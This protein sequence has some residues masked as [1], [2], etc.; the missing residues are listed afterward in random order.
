MLHI[1]GIAQRVWM[2]I[3]ARLHAGGESGASLV[4]YALLVSLIALVCIAAMTFLGNSTA[5]SYDSFGSSLAV[6]GT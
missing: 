3:A 4:E 2:R 1:G 6:A 5:D